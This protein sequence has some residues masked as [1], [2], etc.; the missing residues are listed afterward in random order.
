MTDHQPNDL[1]DRVRD[2]YQ[3]AAR[4]VQTLQRPAPMLAA[5]SVSACHRRCGVVL[6]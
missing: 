3:S 5:G 4:T 2:A 6:M 1:E